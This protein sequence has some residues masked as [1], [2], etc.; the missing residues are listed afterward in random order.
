MAP[1]LETPRLLVRGWTDDDVPPFVEMMGD[2]CVMEFYEDVTPRDESLALAARVREALEHDGYGWFVVEVKG[3]LPFAGTAVLKAVRFEAHFTPAMEVGWIFTPEAWHQGFATEAARA[4]LDYAFETLAWDEVVAMTAAVNMPSRR[5]MERL[6]M[7]YDPKDD[8]DNPA[9][10]KGHRLERHV[11]YRM[12]SQGW[13]DSPRSQ[14][15]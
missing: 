8:F 15:L 12:S 9:V 4:L 1:I 3:G 7:T 10:S 11:L 6:G 5:V 2:P 14:P 13:R